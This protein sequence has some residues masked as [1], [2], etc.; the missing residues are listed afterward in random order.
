MKELNWPLAVNG[1]PV[2][3]TFPFWTRVGYSSVNTESIESVVRAYGAH[4]AAKKMVSE[5]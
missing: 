1:L 4:A 5:G 2:E 3:R